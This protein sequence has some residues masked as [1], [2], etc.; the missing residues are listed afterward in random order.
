MPPHLYRR[1]PLRQPLPPRRRALLL[2]PHHPQT[3]HRSPP[4][5]LPPLRLRPALAR[6]SLRHSILHRPGPAAHSL[7]RHR[8]TPRRSPALRPPDRQPQPAPR[9]LVRPPHHARSRHRRRDRPRPRVRNARSTLRSR[10]RQLPSQPRRR[11]HR[12]THRQPGRR[13]RPPAPDRHSGAT[14][15]R[16]TRS[17]LRP[18]CGSRRRQSPCVLVATSPIAPQSNQPRHA[19]PEQAR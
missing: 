10:T 12:P 7:Q 8:L 16:C 18:P 5:P 14:R 11:A 13:R 15:R 17:G 4:P 19:S 2:P 6:G 1:P 3:H 9:P